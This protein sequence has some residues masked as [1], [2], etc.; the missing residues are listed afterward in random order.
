MFLDFFYNLRAAGVPVSAHN[1]LALMRAL[2]DGLHEDTLDGFYQVAR[3]LLVPSET[4]YDGFDQAFGVTF[5]GVQADLSALVQNLDAWLKDPKRLAWR[6]H[7]PAHHKQ[8]AMC[9]RKLM[10]HLDKISQPLW[11]MGQRMN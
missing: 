8:R 1:W 3:C 7:L 5:R 11:L 6:S 2:A 9:L 10:R 4:H